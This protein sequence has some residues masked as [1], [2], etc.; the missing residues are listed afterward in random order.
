MINYESK[1]DKEAEKTVLEQKNDC[2]WSFMKASLF[3]DR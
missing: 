3:E 2:S 1:H